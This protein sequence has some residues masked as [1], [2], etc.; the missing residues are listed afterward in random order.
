MKSIEEL[1]GGLGGTS[2]LETDDVW[3][4]LEE[5]GDEITEPIVRAASDS[6]FREELWTRYG[7]LYDGLPLFR[8]DNPTGI[9]PRMNKQFF[10][11]FLASQTMSWL[12]RHPKRREEP[13]HSLL[14][15]AQVAFAT[16]HP[17]LSRE[18]LDIPDNPWTRFL[19]ACGDQNIQGVRAYFESSLAPDKAIEAASAGLGTILGGLTLSDEMGIPAST[20]EVLD[21]L[22]E[23]GGD[24]DDSLHA[25]IGCTALHY[26]AEKGDIET[27][28]WLLRHGA[29]INYADYDGR[30][31]LMF[32]LMGSGRTDGQSLEEQRQT[33]RF[34]L[35]AGAE[36]AFQ[37]RE[38][39]EATPKSEAFEFI[40]PT[41]GDFATP[42][43]RALLEK[44]GYAVPAPEWTE[45]EETPA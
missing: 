37:K 6:A 35:D 5:R 3:S 44:W 33:L 41:A 13:I 14:E 29:K 8:R 15:R 16:D 27:L 34:L 10:L 30:T 7:A 24:V 4:A 1:L 18:Q 23:R 22:A 36:M 43:I 19:D 9:G 39:Y 25:N 17:G 45:D 2:A 20:R 42:E 38:A 11:G 21:Y 32:A 26:A 40:G 31:A 28:D 12:Q